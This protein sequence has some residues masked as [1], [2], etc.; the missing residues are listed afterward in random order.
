M[1][2]AIAPI[3]NNKIGTCPHGLPPGACPICSGAGGGGGAKKADFS[4]KAGEMSW[5]QCAAIGAFLKAQQMAKLQKQ[6]Q[7]QTNLIAIANFQNKMTNLAQKIADF[8]Q[9]I[10]TLPAVISKPLTFVANKIM[11]PLI[12]ALKNLPASIQKFADIM[13]KLNA[14]FGELKNATEKKISDKLKDF[15]KKFK[16]LFA[17]FEPT[18]MDEDEDEQKRIFELKTFIHDLYNKLTKEHTYEHHTIQ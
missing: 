17:I 15:K 4:A 10:S 6:N 8:T 11:L 16:S 13:D 12:N 5:S 18:E 1:S 7:V 14:M 2:T 9:R 3:Q